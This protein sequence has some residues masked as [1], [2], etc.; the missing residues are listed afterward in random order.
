M[1]R[2]VQKVFNQLPIAALIR[3]KI[4]ITHGGIY[5]PMLGQ[6]SLNWEAL[7]PRAL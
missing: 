2:R 3:N 4:F 5:S 7:P 1:F 6:L